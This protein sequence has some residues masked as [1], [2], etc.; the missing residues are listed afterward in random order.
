M[1][2]AFWAMSCLCVCNIEIKNP[3]R[4]FLSSLVRIESCRLH[5]ELGEGIKK[6]VGLSAIVK[7]LDRSC[8]QKTIEPEL[9]GGNI[10]FV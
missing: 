5:F 1:K 8:D 4:Q 10:G 3:M 7:I 9:S 2:D 6:A